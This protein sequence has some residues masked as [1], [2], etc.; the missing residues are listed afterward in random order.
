[1]TS[2]KLSIDQK[3]SERQNKI[4]NEWTRLKQLNEAIET[5]HRTLQNKLK[6]QREAFLAKHLEN[7]RN[8]VRELYELIRLNLINWSE[9]ELEWIR[10]KIEEYEQ[11]LRDHQDNV[12]DA[13]EIERQCDE[14][15]GQGAP[16]KFR[17]QKNN[18]ID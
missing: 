10:R 4:N 3:I 15:F 17:P 11:M 18:E 1:M 2:Y 7:I 8:H 9:A 6:A 13:A 14:L 5:E 16:I 12:L